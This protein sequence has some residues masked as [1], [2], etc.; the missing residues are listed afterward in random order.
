MSRNKN[1]RRSLTCCRESLREFYSGYVTKLDVEHQAAE[2][3]MLA[4][5]EK[6]LR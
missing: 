2:L 5:G 6:C 4:V 1:D 3:G